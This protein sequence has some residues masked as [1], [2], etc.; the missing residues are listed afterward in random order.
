MNV[1]SQMNGE[2]QQEERQEQIVFQL[3]KRKLATQAK[4][5]A[6]CRRRVFLDNLS[7]PTLFFVC[8]LLW[9]RDREI[10]T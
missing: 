5:I 1:D 10:P 2:K 7:W 8:I 9:L 4:L 6:T 3:I